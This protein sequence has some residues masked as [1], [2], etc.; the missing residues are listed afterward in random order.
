MQCAVLNRSVMSDP[1]DPTNYGLEGS[2]VHGILQAR[3]LEWVA[4]SFSNHMQSFN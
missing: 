1:C 4:I 2:S 3:I